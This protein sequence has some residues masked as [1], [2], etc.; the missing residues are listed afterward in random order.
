MAFWTENRLLLARDIKHDFEAAVSAHCPV[1]V[2]VLTGRKRHEH[3]SDEAITI[4]QLNSVSFCVFASLL[5]ET[6][7]CHK[8]ATVGLQT[9]K[10]S[11]ELL[12]C[13]SADKMF[14]TVPLA[15]NECGHSGLFQNNI[16]S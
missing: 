4:E 1:N 11:V 16:A 12:E 7:R 9:N 6:A 3:L 14:R 2:I 8:Y 15:L 10:C 5:R 13:W